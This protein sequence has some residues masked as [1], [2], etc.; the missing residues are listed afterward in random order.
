MKPLPEALANPA[1]HHR[2][3]HLVKLDGSMSNFGSFFNFTDRIFGTRYLPD[4]ESLKV[5][6]LG[7]DETYE[8]PPTF[9]KQLAAPFSW[10][11][12]HKA[13]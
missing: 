9:L 12:I 4:R 1:V 11:K 5:E 13:S 10:H 3:H 8:M 6:P 2:A 7:L